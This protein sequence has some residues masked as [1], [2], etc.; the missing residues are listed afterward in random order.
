META[1]PKIRCK[2][3]HTVKEAFEEL[4]KEDA[5]LEDMDLELGD[6][7]VLRRAVRVVVNRHFYMQEMAAYANCSQNDMSAYLRGMSDVPDAAEKFREFL[8]SCREAAGDTAPT[9]DERRRNEF[10]ELRRK[11]QG[12]RGKAKEKEE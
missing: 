11:L 4:R 1:G 5:Y 6:P 8:Q 2:I 12:L 10:D 7:Y 3:W 9:E